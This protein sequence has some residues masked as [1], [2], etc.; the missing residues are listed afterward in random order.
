[1][2]KGGIDLKFNSSLGKEYVLFEVEESLLKEILEQTGNRGSVKGSSFEQKQTCFCSD[3]RTHKLKLS[4][5][6]NL[7]MVA[8]LTNS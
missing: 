6:S 2:Q 3:S 1:M 4:E 7:L 8:D 5:T